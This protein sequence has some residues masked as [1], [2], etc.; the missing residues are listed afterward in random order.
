MFTYWEGVREGGREEGKEG[1]A[2]PLEKNCEISQVTMFTNCVLVQQ[3][4][5]TVLW[6]NNV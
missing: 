6:S 3:F 2:T 4:L 1:G 5:N